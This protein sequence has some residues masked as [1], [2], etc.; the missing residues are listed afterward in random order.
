MSHTTHPGLDALWLTEAVRLREEQAGPLEDSEAVRQALAQG[1][2]LPRRILTR[3]HWLGRREGLLD[4]LRT[5]RQ[6]SRLALA[7][8]LVLALASG[9]GLAFAALGDGQRPVNVFWALASLLGLHLLT[10]LGWALGLLAGGEAAGAL[11][12]L[13]LWLSGKLARDARAAHLAPALLVLLGR[14]RLARWGLGALV[15][16]LWLLGLL[17]A[18]AM[19]LGLLATRRY[20][21]VWETTILG[22]DT[23]IALTQ[24]LGALPA[25][26]GFPLPDAELIR[27]SGD[28]ALASEAAR[29]A[30][31][32]W[33]VGVLL[34]YGVLPRA[35]LGLLCLWRWKRGL[36]HLDLD[37]DDPGYSLLRER[38][39]PASE[40][41]GVS[42]AAPDWLPEP[43]GGQSGQE[44]AGAVL[45]AVELDDRR[46]WPPKLAERWPGWRPAM[47][48]PLIL[49]VVGHTNTGKTSLLRTLTRDRG[50]GEVSHRPSTTRHVEGA[51][52]SVDGEALLELYDTPGLED[53]IALLDYLD[54]LERPGERLDGPERMAR[55]LDSN[56]ARGR[57]EQEAKV[58]RQLLASDAGLY[59]ID[60]REP[61]LAK[62]RDE[63][64]VLAGCGRPLLPVLNFVA[65]PQHR[66][67]EWR[68]ALARLGLH[69]LVR[70]DSVAPPL[71]GER[72]LYES[73]AL[74]LERAR[75]QLDRL[76]ADHETQAAARLRAGQRLIAELLVD[77][78]ACRRL[79]PG[80]ESAVQEA[81]RD[82]H[83][84]V[85]KRE[86]A[87][88]EALLRLYAFARDD[89]RAADLPLLDGR[90]GDDLFNPETLRQL[91]IRLGGGVAAGAAAGAGIDLLVGGVTLGAAAALGALAG[92]AWQ[93]V[94]HYGS[95]LL[96]KLKGA[97]ELTVN[98]AVLRLLA[99]RQ[100][101]LLAA[102][103]TRGHAA[104]EAIR[105]ETPE[106][107]QWREGK[108]PE[109]L[110]K[111]RAHPEWSSLN[112]RRVGGSDRQEQIDAL[113]ELLESGRRE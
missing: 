12:R 101:Q 22:S 80:G 44:A 48:E 65:S 33:L 55:L 13:W 51:R 30:W 42:D 31:A 94:G 82:L 2:S 47:T 18:L 95:R 107:K 96:G 74:L 38:L 34:V 90:W 112:G 23:F 57:F 52:L 20:G 70:F 3:A 45:V 43:Q 50:F 62:Y 106:D 5:W 79:V 88:V 37:L 81:T 68:A 66:E 54:A 36:A 76:I 14:R 41:L 108:L 104:V 100:R 61:V 8:L 73:L 110:R 92:G 21:F 89:A 9:A 69:A 58:V 10:L 77:V 16:G 6:G 19:L 63:L 102:L 97:R 78:A 83:Q 67:E 86:Q 25:L 39:M 53:A 105:L 91:G 103:Q 56:E 87:C 93:T 17:T 49:A 11:G 28:A 85:R 35:L 72:R 75:P 99:L 7:L 15:H 1:G 24:A 46:P 98:D 111:A 71:D 29:H 4:A 113:A 26:L 59:V 64:A 40:R 109:A 84:Q 60:A 32:G 27:A